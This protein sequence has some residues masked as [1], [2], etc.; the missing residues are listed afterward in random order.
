VNQ[1]GAAPTPRDARPVSPLALLA[2]IAVVHACAIYANLS[3]AV[4]SSADYRFFPPFRRHVNA[5]N[6]RDLAAENFNIARSLVSGQGF[7][8]PFNGPSGLTAWMPPALPGVLAGL[9]WLCG[10]NRDAV[11]AVVVFVQVQVLAGTGILVLLLALRTTRH[12]GAALVVTLFLGVLLCHFDW[13]FQTTQDCWIVLLAVDL[14][15]I[16]TCWLRP[17][18]RWHTAA[19]WGL[20]GGL[21]ALV[22]PIVGFTW[23]AWSVLAGLRQKTASR[24]AVALLLAGLTLA[25]WTMRNYLV[26]GRLVPIKSNLAYEL[27]QS[28][29]VQDDGLLRVGTF[30][31]HPYTLSTREGRDYKSLGEMAYL[32]RKREQFCHAVARDPMNYLQRVA[33]RAVCVTLWYV[34]K[35]RGPGAEQP[36]VVWANRL[37]HPLPFL[38]LLFLVLTSR[39]ADVGSTPWSLIGIYLLYLLPY[40]AVSY[41]DRYAVPVLAVKALLMIGAV[42]RLVELWEA[43]RGEAAAL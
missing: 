33:R 35:D 30:K 10:G 32:D 16:G 31:Q 6:N 41:Y 29:C 9:L 8:H 4:R 43:R 25:P 1:P 14:L 12:P 26:F 2:L 27:Y 24:L 22:N 3:F 42:D 38:A 13:C 28:Q 40:V 34:P 18:H 7:A 21:C 15:I 20:F 36:W 5:N 11:M 37:I 17:L 39:C 23:G 19:G